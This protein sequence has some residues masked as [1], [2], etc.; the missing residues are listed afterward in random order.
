MKVHLLLYEVTIP[1]CN[2]GIHGRPYVGNI[3]SLNHLLNMKVHLLLYEVTIPK[4]NVGIH[5]RPYV[6]NIVSLNQG[7]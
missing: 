2:V 4:C 6:G 1:K 3:V 5:G 7:T